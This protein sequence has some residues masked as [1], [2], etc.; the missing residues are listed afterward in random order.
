MLFMLLVL[1]VLQQLLLRCPLLMP[2][3]RVLSDVFG[4]V[5]GLLMFQIN[6]ARVTSRM[7]NEFPFDFRS[8]PKLQPL[9]INT[10]LEYLKGNFILLNQ[11]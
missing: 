10:N 9:F 6:K 5:F 1:L 3:A 2:L 7:L 8:I 4:N 11:R